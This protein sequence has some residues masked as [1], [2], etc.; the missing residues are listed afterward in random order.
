MYCTCVLR[1]VH[2]P[3]WGPAA[4]EVDLTGF[5]LWF[6]GTARIF[7]SMDNIAHQ[8]L[9]EYLPSALLGELRSVWKQNRCLDRPNPLFDCCVWLV[10]RWFVRWLLVDKI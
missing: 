5:L 7:A 6:G 9:I 3:F 8:S 2:N 10:F 4:P 1:S